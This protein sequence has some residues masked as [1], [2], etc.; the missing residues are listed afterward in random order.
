DAEGLVDL[1]GYKRG[2]RVAE[3]RTGPELRNDTPYAAVLEH[4]RR[5]MRPG[6]PVAPIR[7]WAA[8]KLGLSGPELD[9]VAWAVRNAIHKRGTRPY[10]VMFRTQLQMRGWF[11]AA[12]EARLRTK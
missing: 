5:P 2:F 7:E 11:R 12:V 10:K 4:G 3:T 8:R 9:R 1:G 6:P